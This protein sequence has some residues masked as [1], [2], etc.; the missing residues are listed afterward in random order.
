M[1][2]NADGGGG[3][4]IEQLA[5]IR[6]SIRNY[7]NSLPQANGKERTKQLAK[8]KSHTKEEVVVVSSRRM[9]GRREAPSLYVYLIGKGNSS[10]RQSTNRQRE[11]FLTNHKIVHRAPS[12]QHLRTG[13]DS[14]SGVLL[15]CN[16][17]GICSESWF[18]QILLDGQFLSLVF[19][20]LLGDVGELVGFK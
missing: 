11:Y 16:F 7:R 5:R 2:T 15:V 20:G 12:A 14:D 18:L 3:I 6:S 4:N 10:M 19:K 9:N 1:D 13:S 17:V 8:N